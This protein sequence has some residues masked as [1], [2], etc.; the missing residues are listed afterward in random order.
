V[1]VLVAVSEILTRIAVTLRFVTGLDKWS[2]E[3]HRLCLGGR[4]WSIYF[5]SA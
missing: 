1:A 3:C 5:G 2:K 4:G